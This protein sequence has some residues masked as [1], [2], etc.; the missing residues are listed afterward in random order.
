MNAPVEVPVTRLDEFNNDSCLI[1]GTGNVGRQDDCLGWAFIDWLQTG[2]L[3]SNA[4][5]QRNNQLQLNDAYLISK[6]QR[7]LFVDAAKERLADIIHIGAR[8]AENGFQSS[9]S[10]AI[11]MPAIMANP[12]T[13]FQRLP[14]VHVLAI[15]GF[16]FDGN[17][18]SRGRGGGGGLLFS[19]L[20]R[21]CLMSAPR[22]GSVSSAGP[23]RG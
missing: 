5:I 9:T 20:L 15:G 18:D 7:V 22:C 23:L 12:S 14:V 17:R 2:G 3:R 10:H 21:R 8:G 13:V 19:L 4:E 16:E 6:M 11:S 1:Y